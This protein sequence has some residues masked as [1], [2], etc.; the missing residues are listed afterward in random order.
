MARGTGASRKAK[1]NA[2]SE[3]PTRT[4]F[5]FVIATDLGKTRAQ[6]MKM[7]R[8]HVVRGKGRPKRGSAVAKPSVGTWIKAQAEQ[9]VL[10]PSQAAEPDRTSKKDPS[11]PDSSP[12]SSFRSFSTLN[13]GMYPPKFC[14]VYDIFDSCWL[15]FMIQDLLF[16]YTAQFIAE[17]FTSWE[18]GGA[19]GAR[20][21]SLLSQV[22]VTLQQAIEDN[23]TATAD[24]TIGT[25]LFLTLAADIAGD[26]SGAMKHL[27]GLQKIVSIRGGVRKLNSTQLQG[28]C[29][30]ADLQLSMILG[31]RPCFYADEMTWEPFF[32]SIKTKTIHCA[33]LETYLSQSVGFPDPRL[34]AI[35]T[36]V[37]ELCAIVDLS[38]LTQRKIRP[39]L[40]QEVLVSIQYRLLHLSYS[41]CPTDVGGDQKWKDMH[42]AIRLGILGLTTTLFLYREKVDTSYLTIVSRLDASLL[43]LEEPA[44][45]RAWELRVW[46]LFMMSVTLGGGGDR[47]DGLLVRGLEALR[48]KS[49]AATRQLLKSLLWIDL[50]HDE[51]GRM[52]YGRCTGE[53]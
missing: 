9:S 38:I 35:W 1:A 52:V 7:I 40:Y 33:K 15:K 41:K 30:R 53:S 29:Y 16:S 18:Y 21:S 44:D 11:P 31:S 42:E 50:L 32:K 14:L 45:D 36:D 27:R 20:A 10:L 25:V 17:A 46:L 4:S 3:R 2:K 47:F 48:I 43:Q 19:L 26:T 8:S 34:S 28:K 6:D 24:A 22:L 37:Q 12:Q 23:E 49:W 5:P 39:E 13:S 51:V